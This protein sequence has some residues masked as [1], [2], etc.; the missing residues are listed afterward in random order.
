MEAFRSCL[1]GPIPFAALASDGPSGGAADDDRLLTPAEAAERL[2]LRPQ[3]LAR[4]R[5]E[6]FG[7]VFVKLGGRIAYPAR[8]LA[9]WIASNRQH[10]TTTAG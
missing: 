1:L 6:G 5:V 8:E 7:P 10:S 3:T 2:R 4:W 9:S